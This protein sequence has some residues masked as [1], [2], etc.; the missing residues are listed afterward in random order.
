MCDCG[1]MDCIACRGESAR[2]WND[3]EGDST[4]DLIEEARGWLDD[5]EIAHR[6]G[7]DTKARHCI[8]ELFATLE[9]FAEA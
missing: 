5:A 7:D 9:C 4:A 1:A 6:N 8:A 2:Y 3:A